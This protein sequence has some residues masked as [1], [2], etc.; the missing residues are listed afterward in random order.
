MKE[1]ENN[2]QYKLSL[3]LKYHKENNFDF[4][5]KIYKEVLEKSPNHLGGI[6]N[7]ATLYAQSRK[8]RLAKELFLKADNIKPK[9]PNINLNLGNIFFETGD[10]EKALKHF[11]NL[12]LFLKTLLN[13]LKLASQ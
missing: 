5:E 12:I 7:L 1:Q 9:D 13:Y 10:N 4:A 2:T 3:A 6:F 11:D 8:F